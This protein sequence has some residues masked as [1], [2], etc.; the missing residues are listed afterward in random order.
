MLVF[1]NYK[2]DLLDV[3][4]KAT[5]WTLRPSDL[6]AYLTF[7]SCAEGSPIL[8]SVFTLEFQLPGHFSKGVCLGDNLLS[9]PSCENSWLFY[10]REAGQMSDRWHPT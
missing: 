5:R 9:F 2:A 3:T 1:G 7:L 8:C 10:I 6:R 4:R